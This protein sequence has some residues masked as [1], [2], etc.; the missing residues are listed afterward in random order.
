MKK[1]IDDKLELITFWFME[2]PCEEY[3]KQPRCLLEYITPEE[4]YNFIE[5]KCKRIRK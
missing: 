1:K 2:F 3:F 5:K 4:L